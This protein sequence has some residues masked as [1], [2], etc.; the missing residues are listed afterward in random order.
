MPVWP[1]RSS[2]LTWLTRRAGPSGPSARRTSCR[3]RSR[4]GPTAAARAPARRRRRPRRGRCRRHRRPRGV[5]LAD[6]VRLAVDGNGPTDRSPGR[7]Q[8]QPP[9]GEFSFVE[10]LD[11]R[12]ADDAGG[13]DDGDGEG[14]VVHLR[15]GSADAVA[16]DGHGRSIARASRLRPL[17]DGDRGPTKS[18]EERAIGGRRRRR[19]RSGRFS[20]D[21]DV[22]RAVVRELA[23]VS[24]P[25]IGS[26]A[27]SPPG[28]P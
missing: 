19:R 18:S 10:D 20:P 17:N 16:G 3:S 28:E 1:S 13:S 9:D 26:R 12:P 24:S 5:G 2:G 21:R 14:F 27:S 15:H 23:F 11:H 6:L 25:P 22:G 7:E 8:T 4:R